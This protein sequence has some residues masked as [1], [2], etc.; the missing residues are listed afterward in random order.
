MTHYYFN[1]DAKFR[2]KLRYC[3]YLPSQILLLRKVL[4]TVF[5]LSVGLEFRKI[6]NCARSVSPATA[7]KIS[8]TTFLR[9]SV[10]SCRKY[11]RLLRASM[12]RVLLLIRDHW[13]EIKDRVV[14]PCQ[15]DLI[16]IKARSNR[17]NFLGLPVTRL[18]TCSVSE[19]TICALLPHVSGEYH[20]AFASTPGVTYPFNRCL[21]IRVR[22]TP[23][24]T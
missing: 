13:A 9:C 17:T 6:S 16:I 5:H 3:N 21:T 7:K 18:V 20:P 15:R 2:L 8:L 19:S 1:H 11:Q 14:I 12:S 4:D 24:Q 22:E 23:R 10:Q